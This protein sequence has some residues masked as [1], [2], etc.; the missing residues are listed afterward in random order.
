MVISNLSGV[1]E[2]KYVIDFISFLFLEYFPDE[3]FAP[4]TSLHTSGVLALT[5]SEKIVAP[6]N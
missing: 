6:N 5:L 4:K 3:S 1:S 2:Q